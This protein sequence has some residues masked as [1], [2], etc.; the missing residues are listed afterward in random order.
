VNLSYVDGQMLQQAWSGTGYR[1]YDHNDHSYYGSVGVD[2]N[3]LTFTLDNLGKNLE[4]GKEWEVKV[5]LSDDYYADWEWQGYSFN[6]FTDTVPELKPED[7]FTPV[8]TT[9]PVGG[10][11]ASGEKLT[12]KWETNF[13]PK[14]MQ[15]L[16]YSNG[17]CTGTQ[18]L[19][20][21]ATTA[22]VGA[23]GEYCIIRAYYNDSNYVDS[24]KFYVTE[25]EVEPYRLGDVNNDG[26]ID[27]TD[28]LRIKGHFL[29]TYTIEGS[30]LVAGD[31]NKDSAID[32]TDYLRIKG[33]FLGTYTI[34]G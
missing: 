9:Q 32:S 24:N 25:K 10:E 14:K 23:G 21:N 11:V 17:Y 29:G 28:Y 12:V 15:V 30:A 26:A 13:T 34:E 2:T 18:N 22:N 5:Y 19:D 8:F 33:H 16:K 4:P 31:V 20:V 7:V 3:W 6:Y 1:W 27:S